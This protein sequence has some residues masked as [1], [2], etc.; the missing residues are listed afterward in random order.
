MS[1]VT[2]ATTT[3]ALERY[4]AVIGIEIHCQLR[5]A[6]KMFCPCSTAYDGA[7]PNSHVCPVCLGLPGSLPVIN[8]KA[9]EHVLMTGLAIGASIPAATRWDRK[10]YFYPDL[11]K[12]YQISQYDLPLAS[13][14]SLTFGTSEGPFTVA[15]HPSP[16]RGGH[17]EARPCHRSGRGEGQP[18][19]LQPLRGAADGDRHRARRPHR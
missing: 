5:T 14:G 9:V 3:S 4:E 6:S 19:R 7:P 16:S 13:L 18:R 12:G 2:P 15:H 10:N 17:R 11:P 8:R 1:A